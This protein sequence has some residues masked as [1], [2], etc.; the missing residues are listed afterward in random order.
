MARLRRRYL[1]F[2]KTSYYDYKFKGEGNGATGAEAIVDLK[3]RSRLK[4]TSPHI[5]I[6]S[7]S[8]MKYQYNPSSKTIKVMGKKEKKIVWKKT[9]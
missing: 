2:E 6:P 8:F 7:N 3:K 5:A 4:N 1:I 9:K